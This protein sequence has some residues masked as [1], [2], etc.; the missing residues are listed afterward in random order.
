MKTLN[1][2]VSIKILTDNGCIYLV[3]LVYKVKKAS[4]V[5]Q[6]KVSR[7]DEHLDKY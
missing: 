3:S 7:Q 6:V 4:K 5:I 1:T 2:G